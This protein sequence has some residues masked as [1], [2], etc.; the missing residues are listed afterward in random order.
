MPHLNYYLDFTVAVFIVENDRVLLVHHRGLNRWLP[1]G[2]HIDPG[3]DPITAVHR[4]ALEE[5]GLRIEL[6]LDH[7]LPLLPDVQVLPPP[8]YMDIHPIQGQHQH[9]GMV[10]FA[11]PIEGELTLASAEHH[12]IRWFRDAE[13]KAASTD[14]VPLNVRFYAQEALRRSRTAA[15]RNPPIS[16]P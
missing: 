12:A 8:V 1:V 3:E 7:E 14:E 10:Y 6:L 11:R 13:I 2:G 9:L 5:S 15:T 4:E 16:T